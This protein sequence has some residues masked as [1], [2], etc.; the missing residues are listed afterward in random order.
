MHVYSFI[1]SNQLRT[2]R[3]NTNKAINEQIEE[4]S[5]M[6]RDEIEKGIRIEKPE[7][8][9]AL[10]AKFFAPAYGFNKFMYSEKFEKTIP[11]ITNVTEDRVHL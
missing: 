10:P 9:L 5:V 3:N 4:Y 2:F 7:A 8:P 11:T 6:I 1:H